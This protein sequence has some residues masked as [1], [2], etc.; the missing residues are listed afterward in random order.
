MIASEQLK[1]FQSRL[2]N[3]K[4]Q[5]IKDWNHLLATEHGSSV[6]EMDAIATWL[7]DMM[8]IA[9]IDRT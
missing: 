4:L 9:E 1:W 3:Q 2:Q 6:L 8:P 5:D 7:G